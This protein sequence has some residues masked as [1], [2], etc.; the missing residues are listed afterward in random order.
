VELVE[1]TLV[2]RHGD[3]VLEGYY[4]YDNTWSAPRP[5]VL[6]SH[7]WLGRNDF[8]IDKARQL[9]RLG[10][11][12]FAL[13]IYGQGIVG[14]NKEDGARLMAPF[15]D[16]RGLLQQRMLLALEAA[17]QLPIVDAAKIAAIGFC[18]GG[19]CVLDLARTGVAIQGV[20]S[21][22][23]LLDPPSNA[24]GKQ[25]KAKVL[26]L[27]GHDDPMAT[28]ADVLAF[29][30]EMTQAGADWQF[31]S[32]GHTLHAFTNPA[33]NDPGFGTVYQPDADRRSWVAMR[34][35]F[36]ELFALNQHGKSVT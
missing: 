31:V 14:K 11:A 7:P 29:Q 17:K 6:V 19:L 34:N 21:F 30:N 20:V 1:D 13:D 26:A 3:K 9:A 18:F 5:L 33:A 24:S 27:H 35:F 22:H 25:V 23:G 16:D 32:Y 28:P 10:Y 8:V 2:Y 36:D 15:M 12:G 4:A